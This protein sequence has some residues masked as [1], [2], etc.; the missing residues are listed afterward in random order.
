MVV[1]TGAVIRRPYLKDCH[2][3]WSKSLMREKFKPDVATP[4]AVYLLKNL[5]FIKIVLLIAL[6]PEDLHVLVLSLALHFVEVVHYAHGSAIGCVVERSDKTMMQC[7]LQ[8]FPCEVLVFCL[9]AK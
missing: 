7:E 5:V 1:D 4:I 8:S 2:A 3:S 9:I 6:L